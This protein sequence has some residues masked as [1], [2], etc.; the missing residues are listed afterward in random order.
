MENLLI[1]LKKIGLDN[2][3]EIYRNASY[4][5]LMKEVIK[6]ILEQL[7]L[8]QEFLLDVRLRINISLMRKVPQKIFGGKM[9]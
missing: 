7:L 3:G 6:L 8:I 5:K 1:D 2:I 4:D 9:K